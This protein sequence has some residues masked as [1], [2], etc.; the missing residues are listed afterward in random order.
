M[1]SLARKNLFEDLPRFLIAQAGILFAVSLVT[2]QTGLLKGFTQSTTA[3][4]DKSQADLWVASKDLTNFELTLPISYQRL[5]QAQK[6]EGVAS[7][8]PLILNSGLWRNSQGTISTVRV[9]G[10]DPKGKLFSPGVITQGSVNALAQPYRIIVDQTQLKS[11]G[12]KQDGDV[13]QIGSYKA[14]LAGQTTGI[15]SIASSPYL[16]TSLETAKAYSY[17][18]PDFEAKPTTPDIAA[19]TNTDKITYVLIKAKPGQNLQV[20]KQRLEKALPNTLAFTT[21]EIANQTQNYWVQRTSIGFILGLGAI[22]GIIVG[23]VI[24]GQILYASVSDHLKEF[25]T[26][27]AMGASDW[28]TNRIIIEQALWMALLGYIPGMGLCLGLGTWTAATQGVVILIT[29][30]MAGGVL[31]V[32]VFMC[33]GSALFAIQK[34][35]RVDPAMVFKS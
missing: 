34:I 9:I 33:I 21:Q 14:T 32:T 35:N 1:V 18:R 5:A 8:E 17:A 3:L 27:K 4:I 20:L 24:V 28:A 15:Q 6:V 23:I 7:A 10:F 2:I 29:P 22:V 16:L 13:G 26:L 30:V 25:G 12:I 19:L 31:A 11:L